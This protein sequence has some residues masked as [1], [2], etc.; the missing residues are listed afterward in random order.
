MLCLELGWRWQ[1]NLLFMP[2]QNSG[3]ICLLKLGR[4]FH[5]QNSRNLWK[6]IILTCI[7]I[8]CFPVIRA[9]DSLS[10]LWP[11]TKC[12]LTYLLTY[13][14]RADEEWG[15]MTNQIK[16]TFFIIFWVFWG[17]LGILLCG[18]NYGTLGYFIIP[19]WVFFNYGYFCQIYHFVTT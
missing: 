15:V 17:I 10:D 6:H 11:V 8:N 4:Q 7:L 19:A 2:V 9:S 5:I 18:W 1:N 12:S 16:Q 13:K 3:I 14:S